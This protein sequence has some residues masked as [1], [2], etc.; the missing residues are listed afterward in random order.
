MTNNEILDKA[1]KNVSE[2]GYQEMHT[3]NLY[4]FPECFI[5]SHAFA[6]A[7]WGTG[8]PECKYCVHGSDLVPDTCYC[9]CPEAWEAHLQQMILEED[10][11]KY[12]EQFL[13]Q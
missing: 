4:D 5:F 10:P 13:N 7:F 11:I 2:N 3:Y 12:L 1:F 8:N 6:K 9:D